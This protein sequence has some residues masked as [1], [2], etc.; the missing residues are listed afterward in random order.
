MKSEI[1][2]CL[3]KNAVPVRSALCAWFLSGYG[4]FATL[5]LYVLDSLAAKGT[6]KL[7]VSMLRFSRCLLSVLRSIEDGVNNVLRVLL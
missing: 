2:R 4:I 6:S 3:S 5:S 1:V 7:F